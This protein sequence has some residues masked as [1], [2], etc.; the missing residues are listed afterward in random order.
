MCARRADRWPRLQPVHAS[1]RHCRDGRRPSVVAARRHGHR[2][3]GDA[4]AAYGCDGSAV[5]ANEDVREHVVSLQS[6]AKHELGAIAGASVCTVRQARYELSV[7]R[8]SCV[9]EGPVADARAT[10]AADGH[11]SRA[12]EPA[13]ARTSDDVTATTDDVVADASSAAGRAAEGRGKGCRRLVRHDR[14]AGELDQPEAS[15]E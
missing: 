14:C 4:A 1:P 5:R 8:L 13:V 7:G 11:A 9:R 3:D 6:I 15:A 10:D 2:T 12:D